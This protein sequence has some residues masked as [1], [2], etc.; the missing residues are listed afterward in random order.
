MGDAVQQ[1][2]SPTLQSEFDAMRDQRDLYRSLL[3]CEPEGLALFM[4]DALESVE[5]IR[6]TLRM[7]TR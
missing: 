4:T 1:L 5:C 3:S 6:S 2:L 7:S